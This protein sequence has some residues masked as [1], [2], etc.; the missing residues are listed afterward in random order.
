MKVKNEVYR[1]DFVASC[2]IDKK[3]FFLSHLN[4]Q[5]KTI[6]RRLLYYGLSADA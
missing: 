4:F 1:K 5:I 3:S 2:L 6:K